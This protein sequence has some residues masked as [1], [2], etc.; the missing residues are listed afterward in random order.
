MKR[1]W[2]VGLLVA[3]AV[4]FM[5]QNAY[6][7]DINGYSIWAPWVISLRDIIE[8]WFGLR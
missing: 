6:A 3:A 4:T 1:R 5:S 8:T 2:T 7:I